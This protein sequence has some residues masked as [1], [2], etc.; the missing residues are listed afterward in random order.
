MVA[1]LDERVFQGAIGGIPV[2]EARRWREKGVQA[3]VISSDAYEAAMVERARELTGGFVPV[4][5]VYRPELA[6][7]PGASAVADSVAGGF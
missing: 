1:I 7:M 6:Y 4:L 2:V 3:V 5:S